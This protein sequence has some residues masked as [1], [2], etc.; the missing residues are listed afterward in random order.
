MV[1]VCGACGAPLDGD[2][3][4]LCN[5][6]AANIDRWTKEAEENLDLLGPDE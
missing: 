3:P 4:Y 6:C 1:S 2:H 5:H